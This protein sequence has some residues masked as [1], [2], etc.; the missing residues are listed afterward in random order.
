MK[1]RV[2]TKIL[3]FILVFSLLLPMVSGIGVNAT[4][5]TTM[6]S[7]NTVDS[8]EL[9]VSAELSKES[10]FADIVSTNKLT[11]GS[12]ILKH[13]DE[14]V[15]ASKNHI[16]R[17]P[18]EETLS[19]YVFRNLD[20][21]K[22]VYYM[23]KEVKY[24]DNS[25]NIVEKDISLSSTT[26][27]YTT[28]SNDVGL[29]LPNNPSNGISLSYSSYDISIVPEGGELR[30]PAQSNGTSVIYPDYFGSGMSLMYTPSLDGLK[31]DIVLSHYTGTNSFAFRLYTDGLHL[32]QAN[33]RYYLAQSEAAKMRIDMGDVVSFDARGRFSVGTM[34]VETLSEGQE[35]R[36]TLTVDA[37]FLTAESTT[38]PVS[39]DPTLTIS[40]STHGAGAIED[41]TIYSGTPTANCDWSYLHCGYYS[42]TYKVGRTLFRLSGLLSSNEYKG[43][44][45]ADIT[46]AEFHIKET[47][48][49]AAL[50]VSIYANT[51]TSTWTET[52]ATWNNAGHV[53]GAQ[54][55]TASP[56]VNEAVSY[57]ITN[58]VKAWKNG[59]ET[60][61]K[62]FILKSSNET[63]LDKAFY[64]S[65]IATISYRP[66]VVVNYQD[67]GSGGGNAFSEATSLYSG[68]SVALSIVNPNEKRYFKFTP[69]NTGFYTLQSSNSTGDP[70]VWL[71]NSSHVELASDDDSGENQDYNFALTYHFIK[72]VT[73]YIAAG[74]YGT[75]TGS[76]TLLI[77]SKTTAAK[78]SASTATIGA[79]YSV[80]INASYA[81]KYYKIEVPAAG[82]YF[83][84]S[85]QEVGDAKVW[86]YKSDLSLLSYNDNGGGNGKF[87][88]EVYLTAN[89]PYYIVVG[90]NGSATGT[91]GFTALMPI[92]IPAN[93]NY[94]HLQNI[95]SGHFLDIHGPIEQELAHQWSL[96]TDYQERW[97][98]H[99]RSD[100]YYTIRSQYDKK[101]YLGVST[102]GIGTNNVVLLPS[103]TDNALW[104][105]Y[106]TPDGELFI[107]P[108]SAPGK[109]ICVPDSYMGTELQ[110]CW[111]SNS[112]GDKN[113]WKIGVRWNVEL[114]GQQKRD[115]CWAAAVRMLVSYYSPEEDLP[116]QSDAVAAAGTSGDNGGT[117]E[118]A[119]R[120]ANFYRTGNASL[121]ATYFALINGEILS[122]DSLQ[123]VLDYG[124]ILYI[125]RGHFDGDGDRN[126]GHA[127]V[128][129]GYTTSVVDGELVYQYIILD[130]YPE[131]EPNPWPSE[132]DP[133]IEGHEYTAS[134]QWIS[135]VYLGVA[136]D[137]FWPADIWV[138]FMTAQEEYIADLTTLPIV[139]N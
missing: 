16:A 48:G 109:V 24:R 32:Y 68:G 60:A 22:T 125:S 29:L 100:G 84:Q 20:G 132:P 44:S 40:D 39:I 79:G 106:G 138:G 49:T 88:V 85:S 102:T 89:T 77:S 104:K 105:I 1:K 110:L 11:Q 57:D 51:G 36:L 112:M 58:L 97:A 61:Q 128:I 50:E 87:R 118:E 27:G 42:S 115:W 78:L 72:N 70:K 96:H 7:A 114:M 124:D 45:A 43:A 75:E 34:T 47:T 41:I 5:D 23:D 65:E 19:S 69:L 139:Y 8:N 86:I 93:Y 92:T 74:H 31:E 119:L 21:T 129:I 116:T 107:E 131:N 130:P 55:A 82:F 26:N 98:I 3:A 76:Y 120:A 33:G 108:K 101:Y 25:G 94:F 117:M 18:E 122:E 137:D 136:P 111:M 9:E 28:A 127:S 4:T 2:Q 121:N 73:Y 52:G 63:T 95:G 83:F 54:Y 113:K 133:T 12:Q 81:V 59:T 37:D 14:T 17:L 30:K 10:I 99:Q 90:H 62:G 53:L 103:V 135:Y 64:S 123:K 71:Y 15:F 91:Y 38:Y 126:G 13:I 6:P 134:Y 46:S 56:G 66:Y 80:T 67:T 35:Y